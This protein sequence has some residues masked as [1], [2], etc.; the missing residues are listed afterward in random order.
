MNEVLKTMEERW[1]TYAERYDVTHHGRTTAE[2]HAQWS[3]LLE[4]HIGKERS[5]SVLDVGAGTGFL[6]LKIAALG[7]DCHGLDLSNGMMDIGR[8]QAVERGL[9]VEFL[10]GNTMSLPVPDGSMD[11][12]TNRSLLWTLLDS[13][14]AFEEWLRV[15]KPGGKVLCF[16]TIGKKGMSGNHYSQEIEDMLELKGASVSKL[17]GCLED[18]GFVEVEA[19][20][21]EGI[22]PPHGGDNLSYVIKGK[23]KRVGN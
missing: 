21:L 2:E 23:K 6:T 3:H 1:D 15:L 16:C 22:K 9:N 20:I 7:Y 17:C 13:R 14:K 10:H 11:V 18:A 5:L 12:I 4:M 19:V 8:R